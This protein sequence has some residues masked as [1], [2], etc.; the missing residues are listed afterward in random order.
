MTG[1]QIFFVTNEVDELGGVGGVSPPRMPMSLGEN[2]PF[3]TLTL[4]ERRPP[5]HHPP[6]PLLDRFDPAVR[7]QEADRR[8]AAERLAG[9]FRAARPGA[10]IL[11]VADDLPHAG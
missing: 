7:E 2:P 10:V 4:Y 6:R 8:A 9:I 11:A 3:E 1:R 5:A